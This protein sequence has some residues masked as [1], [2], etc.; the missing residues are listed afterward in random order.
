MQESYIQEGMAA[1][2]ILLK[3]GAWLLLISLP[4]VIKKIAFKTLF[5]LL[6]IE[7]YCHC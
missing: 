1:K 7:F 2:L 3:Q 5:Q 6:I 4:K